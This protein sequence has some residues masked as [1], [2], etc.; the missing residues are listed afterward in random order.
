MYDIS[1]VVLACKY[2]S[3]EEQSKLIIKEL[4][5][6]GFKYIEAG[7]TGGREKQFKGAF[8]ISD[9]KVVVELNKDGV[10]YP[11]V[12]DSDIYET[13]LSEDKGGMFLVRRRDNGLRPTIREKKKRGETGSVCARVWQLSVGW[14]HEQGKCV[15]HIR[16]NLLINTRD[17]LRI[18][19]IGE[20]RLNSPTVGNSD[21]WGKTK[22]SYSLA[23][24][25]SH[26]LLAYMLMLLGDITEDELNQINTIVNRYRLEP[27]EVSA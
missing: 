23:R 14:K 13:Y 20:N 1:S 8:I 2:L 18:C 16:N 11:V 9:D 27:K 6:R 3:N 21:D 15:D 17:E 19:K 26:T 5:E 24:D 10:L 12:M 22:F 7:K 25:C 4:R